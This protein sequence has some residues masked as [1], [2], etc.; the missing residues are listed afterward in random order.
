MVWELT[1]VSAGGFVAVGLYAVLAFVGWQHR[2]SRC[3]REIAVFNVVVG[4]SALTYAIQVGFDSVPTQVFWW[5]LT[6]ALSTGV[7]FLWLIF[8]VQYVSRSRWLTPG[9]AALFAV[10]PVAVLAAIAT[11]SSHNLVWSVPPGTTATAGSA[12][13]L[14]FGPLYY[15][16]LIL[17]YVAVAVGMTMIF[18]V[19]L[20]WSLVY[21]KQVAVLLV[22]PLPPFLANIAFMFGV[23][24]IPNLDLTPFLVTFTGTLLVLGLYRLDLLERTPIARRRVLESMGDGLVVLDADR[25]VVDVDD[26]A[27]RILDPEPR[28]GQ[29]IDAAF[30]DRSWEQLHGTTVTD[31]HNHAFDIRVSELADE[32]DDEIGYALALRDVT[33]RH[34]YEQR[35]EVANRVLRHNLRN[36]M[37]VVR[38]YAEL[39]ASESTTDAQNAA[40]SILGR[41]DDLLA[42]SDKARKV[43]ELDDTHARTPRTHDITAVVAGAVHQSERRHP[44]VVFSFV[45]SPHVKA[46]LTDVSALATALQELIDL[47]VTHADRDDLVLRISVEDRGDAVV[48]VESN[49]PGIPA[50]DREALAAGSETPLHH[51]EGL[52]LWLAYWCV[53]ENG[54][55]LSF[56]GECPGER[57]HTDD[58]PPSDGGAEASGWNVVAFLTLPEPEE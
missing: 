50:V 3:G 25:T 21:W 20:R 39:V 34:R 31:S 41:T 28:V 18:L 58:T 5:E 22:A 38:G 29:S 13:E 33:G 26:V 42:V 56:E 15:T 52:S 24:P 55:Q 44:D 53:I 10:E 46:G 14:A 32:R 11:N 27:R 43:S 19:G 45:G 47:I 12:I 7:P 54:G 8:V 30:P 6:F 51:A 4:L 48:C 16:H 35:L 37:N 2:D 36:D 40:E 9:R 23:S 49:G 17:A 1:A 57:A